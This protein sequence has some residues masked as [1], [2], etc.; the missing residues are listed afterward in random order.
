MD[1][2]PSGQIFRSP[3]ETAALRYWADDQIEK[4]KR[5]FAEAPSEYQLEWTSDG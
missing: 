5:A 4:S 1:A 3:R 2:E